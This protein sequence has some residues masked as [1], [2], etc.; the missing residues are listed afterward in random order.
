[1][2]AKGEGPHGSLRETRAR[3]ALAA[4][5]GRT[6]HRA[7][8]AS[9]PS[10]LFRE[11][12]QRSSD[13]NP[14]L[15]TLCGTIKQQASSPRRRHKGDCLSSHWGNAGKGPPKKKKKKTRDKKTTPKNNRPT[16]LFFFFFRCPLRRLWAVCGHATAC[17]HP[18]LA[19]VS[20]F[21]S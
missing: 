17:G 1:M 13:D 20:S 9:P 5:A 18:Q 12:S 19:A 16:F 14:P 8:G 11:R 15:S 4:H 3:H 2:K 10:P 6:L 7:A 21:T